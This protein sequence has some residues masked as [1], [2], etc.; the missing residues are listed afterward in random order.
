[1]AGFD[2]N[3]PRNKDGE[4]TVAAQSAYVGAGLEFPAEGFEHAGW[5]YEGDFQKEH[6]DKYIY[7]SSFE[8][9][10][11]SIKAKGLIGGL[12]SNYEGYNTP[13]VAFA[14]NVDE[15]LYF[16]AMARNKRL[17]PAGIILL[18]AKVSQTTAKSYKWHM[19]EVRS[20]NVSPEV[21]EIWDIAER[22]WRPLK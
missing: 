11:E 17:N 6:G 14:T 19:N 15:A 16:Y 10:L 2:P 21:L 9:N 18:R 7:H 4:W 1:M 8:D 13:E 12:G 20:G 5:D 22:V 3:Q